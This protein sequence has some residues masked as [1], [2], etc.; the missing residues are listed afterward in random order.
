M[1]RLT[2]LIERW[3]IAAVMGIAVILL[4]VGLGSSGLWEPWEMDRADLS[5]AI[6]DPPQ[7]LA[8]IAASPQDQA[9][10]LQTSAQRAGV[11]LR[12]ADFDQG[13]PRRDSAAVQ[14]TLD[15][16]RTRVVSA[17]VLDVALLLDDPD[18]PAAWRSAAGKVN[19]ALGYVPNG[20]VV[21]LE[22]HG[23]SLDE[24]QSRLTVERVRDVWDRAAK[25][26]DLAPAGDGADATR[27][28]DQAIQRV[29]SALPLDPRLV[30]LPADDG[31]ALTVALAGA[32][33]SHASIVRFK[34]HGDTVTVPPLEVWLRTASYKAFGP[35]EFSTRLPSAIFGL[36]TLWILMLAVRNVWGTR[37]AFFSG[38]VLLTTPLFYGQARSAAGEPAAILA[39]TLVACG[40]LLRERATSRRVVW[41]YLAAGFV[42]GFLAKGLY[43]PLLFTVLAVASP[44]IEGATRP[45]RWLPALVFGAVTG[46]LALW[47]LNAPADGF[48]GQFRFTLPLFSEGPAATARNFDLAIREIGFGLFPWSPLV[49]IGLGAAAFHAVKKRDSAVLV[50][51]LW[52]IVPTVL[53]MA[54][55]KDFNQLIWPAVPAAAL[56]VGLLFEQLVARGAK[57]FFVAMALLIMVLLIVRETHEAP[58]GLV[59]YLTIDPP[60]AKKGE[61][62]WPESLQLAHAIKL[63]VLVAMVLLVAYIGR[64][65]SFARTALVFFRRER[66]FAIAV[67][68]LLVLAPLAWLGIIG[69]A[70]RVAAGQAHLA[71]TGEGQLA[72]IKTFASLG[73][74]TFVIGIL[75]AIALVLAVFVKWVFPRAGRFLGDLTGAL[76]G[77]R[78]G[79]RLLYGLAAAT[80][81]SLAIILATSVSFPG[82]YWGDVLLG[83]PSLVGYLGALVLGAMVWRGSGGDRVQVVLVIVGVLGLLVATRL[84]RDAD[85]RDGWV[86]TLVAVGWLLAAPAALTQLLARPERFALGAGLLL[87]LCLMSIDVP[88]LD[89]YRW[90][91]QVLYAGQGSTVLTRLVVPSGDMFASI[92]VYFGDLAIFAIVALFVN[93]RFHDDLAPYARHALRLE[94]GPVGVAAMLVGGVVVAL[95]VAFGFHASLA[96]NVSE[97]HVI[98]AWRDAAGDAADAPLRLFKHGAFAAQGRK[99]ANFYTAGLPEIRDRATALEVL[100]GAHDA[101]A[102]IDSDRGSEPVILPGWNVDN[103]SDR[104]GHRDRQA[105]RG[106][107]TAVSDDSITD[108]AQHWTPGAL[109]GR[110]LVDSDGRTWDITAN[111]ATTVTAAGRGRLTFAMAAPARR[112][113]AIDVA[114][115]AD[116]RATAETPE[117]RGMLLP[118]DA[119]SELNYAYRRISGGRH[120]PV[121]DGS[122][123]RVLLATSW[124]AEGEQ[125]RNRLAN[126]TSTQAEF[127]ALTDRRIKRVWGIF[128]DEIQVVGYKLD[129]P[130][131]APGENYR[132]TVYYKA[133]KPIRKSYKIFMHMD[134]VGASE[135]VHGDHWPLNL[136][137]ETETDKNC[138]GCFRTDHWMPGDIVADT[139][140][141]DIGTVGTG[142]YMIWL[143]FYLPGPDTRLTLRSWDKTNCQSDG[144]NR[145]GIGTFQVR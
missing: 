88:L 130:V 65:I 75:T 134:L 120:I 119:L 100:L 7:V 15:G 140:D 86:I 50:V 13:P 79:H 108:A 124:L 44:L 4:F 116:H 109:V 121:I 61:L 53:M 144:Q 123:Y 71:A 105:V 89:R 42:V 125:Q 56:A 68:I 77:T 10:L 46:L 85:W 87:L 110:K 102:V 96:N 99:D 78:R 19:V 62:R 29:A 32:A 47:V 57:S 114:Q 30:I 74:P 132:V 112:F 127:D 27:Q 17:I 16:A 143:G 2:A 135:R 9:R 49:A 54:T 67:G 64:A 76:T 115:M 55:L 23:V 48:A 11:V 3:G 95:G 35:T 139:Y 8:A 43:G 142:E 28:V 82:D 37:V 5:R 22:H 52:F 25:R 39:L 106:F 80:W 113:Y 91:E 18:D 92:P 136:V 21:L 34:D 69:E 122:S 111:D 73:E 97:K 63:L 141:A 38:L 12:L 66:P 103:D 60:F 117:R 41:T 45:S 104:D 81:L 93:R 94:R 138:M 58:D 84:I 107:A 24:L 128:D 59:A 83:A 51:A 133:L 1:A 31:D 40:L 14:S 131:A 137:T 101:V 118:A 6:A 20:R 36:L 33:A 145:L 70:H 72:F 90:V 98:D 126:A 26:Y 129:E